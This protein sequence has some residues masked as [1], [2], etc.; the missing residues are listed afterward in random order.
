MG[1]GIAKQTTSSRG[2]DEIFRSETNP[3]ITKKQKSRF[4]TRLKRFDYGMNVIYEMDQH[5]EESV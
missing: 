3:S 1:C 2:E 4:S 5:Y